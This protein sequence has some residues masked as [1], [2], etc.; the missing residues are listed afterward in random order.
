MTVIA[1][2][3][4]APHW[5]IRSQSDA[6]LSSSAA[7]C[8]ARSGREYHKRDTDKSHGQKPSPT[9]ACY[10]SGAVQMATT[11][12]QERKQQ[13]EAPIAR[14]TSATK[15]PCYSLLIILPFLGRIMIRIK[16]EAAA[17]VT[18][19]VNSTIQQMDTLR[20]PQTIPTQSR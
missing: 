9:H 18:R 13:S 1:L 14:G 7:V 11:C 3:G 16:I 15:R 2:S 5:N 6:I 10:P 12:N 19:V 8:G 20:M 4:N 17:S